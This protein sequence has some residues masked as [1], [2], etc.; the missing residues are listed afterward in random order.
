LKIELFVVCCGWL[1]K[2]GGDTPTLRYPVSLVN[3][4]FGYLPSD[5]CGKIQAE[6]ADCPGQQRRQQQDRLPFAAAFAS[7]SSTR[8]INVR[9]LS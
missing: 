3:I 6:I 9:T 8:K 5:G 7:S 1:T 4:V 2:A